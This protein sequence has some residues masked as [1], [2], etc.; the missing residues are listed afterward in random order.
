M[1][2]HLDCGCRVR[3][4]NFRHPAVCAGCHRSWRP[5]WGPWVEFPTETEP[6]QVLEL[7]S[8]CPHC[9]HDLEYRADVVR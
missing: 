1:S 8:E 9:G 5:P 4:L 6:G 2:D 7:A 3:L